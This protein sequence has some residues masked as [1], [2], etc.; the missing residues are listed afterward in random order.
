MPTLH[1]YFKCE[2]NPL[3]WLT[4]QSTWH[5]FIS[6]FVLFIFGMDSHAMS[7]LKLQHS[8][9]SCIMYCMIRL[10]TRSVVLIVVH[11]EVHTGVVR[12]QPR[13]C[14]HHIGVSLCMKGSINALNFTASERFCNFSI[15]PYI[16][17]HST[18]REQ[19]SFFPLGDLQI[20]VWTT[21]SYRIT[22]ALLRN[23]FQI[24]FEGL[25]LSS[26]SRTPILKP[27]RI[28][29]YLIPIT[30]C[31]IGRKWKEICLV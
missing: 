18:M 30:S 20:N 3:W 12:L 2:K 4:A 31:N 5:F 8:V 26:I 13:N 7:S 21:I 28:H 17:S 27:N 24:L 9:T 6:A 15:T 25:K 14:K 29:Y 19:P 16:A 1:P 11:L 10:W 23:I 22:W